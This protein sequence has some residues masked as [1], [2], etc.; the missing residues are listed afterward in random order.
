MWG[1]CSLR[2]ATCRLPTKA[3]TTSWCA[4]A[5][6]WCQ[7]PLQKSGARVDSFASDGN[8]VSIRRISRSPRRSRFLTVPAYW[9]PGDEDDSG[10]S[11][12]DSEPTWA[13][14]GDGTARRRRR[15]EKLQ[16]KRAKA[17]AVREQVRRERPS[18][19]WAAALDEAG[20]V[21][22]ELQPAMSIQL[23]GP[24]LSGRLYVWGGRE[25]TREGGH[26]GGRA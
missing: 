2:G 17:E 9:S 1:D 22:E 13:R 26:E 24:Q 7:Q 21:D 23:P 16:K 10:D 25:V 14:S 5:A 8:P 15:R 20:V 11:C 6:T 19:W 4:A 12:S 3:W 18:K